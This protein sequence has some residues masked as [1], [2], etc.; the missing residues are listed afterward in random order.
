MDIIIYV[1]KV[2]TFIKA[3]VVE[4][5]NLQSSCNTT[6]NSYQ[7]QKEYVGKYTLQNT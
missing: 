3:T 2:C 5:I 7:Y 6:S 4:W 1:C